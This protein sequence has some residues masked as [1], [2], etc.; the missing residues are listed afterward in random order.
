MPIPTKTKTAQQVVDNALSLLNQFMPVPTKTTTGQEVVDAALAKLNKLMPIP[1]RSLTA[2]E[3]VDAA[4]VLLNQ[5][6]P[7]PT[8]T[9]TAKSV[10]DE[11]LTILNRMMPTPTHTRTAKEV[12]DD[13]LTILNKLMPTPTYTKTAKEVVDEA[14]TMLNRMM[15]DPTYTVT[16]QEVVDA[17]LAKLNYVNPN[18]T[19][20][21]TRNAKYYTTAIQMVNEIQA[22]LLK[23][24]NPLDMPVAVTAL[25]STLSVSDNT[26]IRVM[27]TALAMQFAQADREIESFNVLSNEY[28]SDKLP[29]VKPISTGDVNMYYSIALPVINE[30]QNELAKI[31]NP[32]STPTAIS[33]L[34][35]DKLSVTDDTATRVM[36]IAVAMRFA[37]ITGMTDLYNILSVEYYK[38]KL[39]SVQ[40]I[41]VGDTNKYYSMSLQI[42]NEVQGDLSKIENPLTVPTKL[43]KLTDT[44]SVSDD[45]AVRVMPFAVA[46]RFAQIGNMAGIYNTISVEYYKEKLPSVKPI[47]VGDT[48]MYYSIA[49]PIINAVQTELARIENPLA[50]PTTVTALTGV[51]SIT[52]F[53]ATC[54]M[55]Y[56]VAARF[57]QRTGMTDLY[58]ALSNE[59]YKEKLPSVKTVSVGD[60][61]MY[62]S[63]AL[64]ILNEFQR[65]LVRKENSLT[66]PTKLTALSN[67]LSVTDDTASRVLP[68]AIAMRFAQM[69]GL[70]AAYTVLSTDYYKEKLPS[71]QTISVG[72]ANKYYSIAL[73][74]INELQIEL[75]QI[76]SPLSAA[77]KLPSLATVLS[78]SDSTARRVMPTALAMKFAQIEGLSAYSTLSDEYYKHDLPL[79]KTISVG[80]SNLYYSIAIP[81]LNEFQRELLHKENPLSISTEL[82]KLSDALSVTDDTAERVF[83]IAV[84]MRFAEIRGFTEAYANFSTEYY[85]QKLPS[86]Q[87]ISVGDGNKY[88][89]ISI[90]LINEIQGDLVKRENPM[91]VVT[92]IAALTDILSITDDTAV[93]VMPTALAMKFAQAENEGAY[94]ILSEEYYKQKLPSIQPISTG[95][96]SKYAST[97]PILCTALQIELLKYEGVEEI[98]DP[99]TSLDDAL[100]VTDATAL[101]VMPYGLA[102]RW[103]LTED[104]AVYND[105]TANYINA[106][107][108]ISAAPTRIFDVYRF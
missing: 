21:A 41:S 7:T 60:T 46:L 16:V 72:D 100:T 74:L 83:S 87:T 36:P 102:A 10:V 2:K 9:T 54:V 11:S 104:A 5:L 45:V 28:Y 86:V 68:T 30:F 64:P 105:M 51:L 22:D 26:A 13:S 106:K 47:S 39:P 91:A 90:S 85:K 25:T 34:F 40:A 37:Q 42:L 69:G 6:M 82:T 24:E 95:D 108:S 62:Y 38:Q 53:T 33:T 50:T 71:V 58:T 94:K 96:T 4:L 81:V 57:A 3:V 8:K 88:Y 12:V 103:S 61:N 18:G 29:S 84:A 19:V 27:P 14:I 98:P 76:E 44:L 63:I 48:N 80:D 99:L 56:A 35:T 101:N 43:T 92:P 79:V 49:L 89:S 23:K 1:T 93:R 97:A 73:P 15:P 66:T 59:Y 67:T 32:L 52:D 78:I 55:P 20:D 75:L 77:T 31:E 70:E 65:E 107:K 17:A